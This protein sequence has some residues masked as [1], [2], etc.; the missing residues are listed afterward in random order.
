MGHHLRDTFCSSCGLLNLVCVYGQLQQ[1]GYICSNI[2]CDTTPPE[3]RHLVS[4][5]LGTYLLAGAG[6]G[7]PA[8]LL[9]RDSSRSGAVVWVGLSIRE[10]TG[11]Y[12][13]LPCRSKH[14]LL[15]VQNSLHVLSYDEDPDFAAVLMKD[16]V[17]KVTIIGV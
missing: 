4:P 14:P 17:Y 13:A 8:G 1:S 2:F 5:L 9:S 10:I 7:S 15:L 6:S 11:P 12:L 3:D 16:Q